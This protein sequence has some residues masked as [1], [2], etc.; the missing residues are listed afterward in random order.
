MAT[1]SNH[2]VICDQPHVFGNMLKPAVC[3]RE[4]CC[5]SFQQLGVGAGSADEIATAAEVVDLL[6][7]L[8]AA[9]SN[10]PRKEVIFEPYP[11]IMDPK[12]SKK[13]LMSPQSKDFNK[14]CEILN[15]MPSIEK[16]ANAKDAGDMK[17]ILDK[18]HPM[19]NDMLSWIISSNRS[20]IVKIPKEKVLF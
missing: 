17:S 20:H 18:A 2:C 10:S 4:L 8:A 15:K 5:W 12:D 1:L 3:T 14:L 13:A 19:A 7:S 16:I 11:T 9:A 6:V